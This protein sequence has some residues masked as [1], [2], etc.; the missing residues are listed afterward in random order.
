M[1]LAMPSKTTDWPLDAGQKHCQRSQAITLGDGITWQT[2]HCPFEGWNLEATRFITGRIKPGRWQQ[3]SM[4][5]LVSIMPLDIYPTSTQE[6]PRPC[7]C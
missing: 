4:Q 6:L 5:I 1:K 3:L 2:G 7:S